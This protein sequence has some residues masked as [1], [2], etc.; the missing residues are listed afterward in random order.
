[1]NASIIFQ[2][3]GNEANDYSSESEPKIVKKPQFAINLEPLKHKSN[4]YLKAK[5]FNCIN[6]E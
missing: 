6:R 3:Q 2:E 1:L 5:L 4:V